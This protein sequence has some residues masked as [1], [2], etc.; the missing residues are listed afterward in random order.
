MKKY[1][2]TLIYKNEILKEENSNKNK[3]SEDFN[4]KFLENFNFFNSYNGNLSPN[5]IFGEKFVENNKTICKI[6][7]QEKEYDLC[8]V[9][10]NNINEIIKNDSDLIEIKLKGINKVIDMSYIFQGCQSLLYSPDIDKLNTI[11]VTNMSHFFDGCIS[12]SYLPDIGKWKI[13]NVTDI[14]Y[15]FYL[16]LS[17]KNLSDIG[18]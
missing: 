16:C 2:I 15:M 3:E 17:M 12:L 13:D 6:I 5:K 11:K 9:L 8:S 4:G 10:P 18:N 14:S 7:I 1:E